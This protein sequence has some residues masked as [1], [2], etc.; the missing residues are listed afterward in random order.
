MLYCPR[1][2]CLSL[3][4][5]IDESGE[6]FLCFFYNLPNT[7]NWKEVCSGL[8]HSYMVFIIPTYSFLWA[9]FVFE[10][11]SWALYL[12]PQGF[13]IL[14]PV[15]NWPLAIL[16]EFFYHLIGNRQIVPSV[17]K[18]SIPPKFYPAPENQL[19]LPCLAFDFIIFE[20][21]FSLD[22]K[23]VFCSETSALW[24]VQESCRFVDYLIFLFILL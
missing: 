18:C 15:H 5:R 17:N 7:F 20:A 12:W 21:T 19:L 24:W 22:F 10:A 16:P 1:P 4:H 8:Y 11:S 23:S 3:F 9:N 6:G 14:I 2:R 13:C